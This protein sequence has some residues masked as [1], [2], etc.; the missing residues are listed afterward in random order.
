MAE[1]PDPIWTLGAVALGGF[2]T[3][4]GQIVADQLKFR[5]EIKRENRNRLRDHLYQLQDQ[6]MQAFGLARR[7][8]HDLNDPFNP[9]PQILFDNTELKNVIASMG[10]Y[11][12]R[13]GDDPLS[14]H[15]GATVEALFY[16]TKST[17]G[18]GKELKQAHESLKA[19]QLRIGELLHTGSAVDLGIDEPRRWD[20]RG[21]H[22]P[23]KRRPAKGSTRSTEN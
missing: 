4:V 19:V 5:Q 7:I 9:A 11:T 15:V 18:G 14:N 12:V 13:V 8:V 16:A 23:K 2:L 17:N 20:I 21:S 10:S 22:G 1:Q 3:I 6:L